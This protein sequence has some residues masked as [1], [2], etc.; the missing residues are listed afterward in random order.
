M[1]RR[2]PRLVLATERGVVATEVA[3]SLATGAVLGVLV[4][5][6]EGGASGGGA[7]LAGVSDAA[8]GVARDRRVRIVPV[9]AAA[10]GIDAAL[11]LG[12][13]CAGASAAAAARAQKTTL[14]PAEVA[15]AAAAH[16]RER[17]VPHA[18]VAG[19]RARAAYE[20]AWEALAAGETS[21]PSPHGTNGERR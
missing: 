11:A 15:R 17:G 19:E 1:A 9:P 13:G 7:G 8:R 4:G 10:S 12:A 21:R 18:D 20:A 16:Y 5:A 3:S 6:R 2:G 14:D